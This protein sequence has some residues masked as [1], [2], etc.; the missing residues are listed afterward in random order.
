MDNRIQ[1]LCDFLNSS[2]SVYHAQDYLVNILNEQG[3]T[4]LP[5]AQA[6]D[7]VPGGK[8]YVCRGN[9]TVIA[10]RI[11][12]R[13]PQGFLITAAHTDRPGF[14]VKE[15]GEQFS[16]AYTRL[17]TE[18]YGSPLLGTWTDRPLSL[19]GRVIVETENGAEIRLFDIDR[20]LMLIPNLA[21]HM[22]R[23]SNDGIK[24]NPA[25][26][27][28]PLLGGKEAK[29]KFHDLMEE[30]AGGKIIGHDLYLYV[31]AKAAIWGID[32]EYISAPALDDL[33]SVWGS[34]QGFLKAEESG[35]VPVFCA[36][37]SEEI[38][39]RTANGADSTIISDVL[40][41]ISGALGLDVRQLLAQ[42]FLISADNA[43]ALHPNHPELADVAN[44]PV[45]G[46]GP[47]L[48]FNARQRYC[49]DGLCAAVFRKVCGKA[50][51]NIQTYYNR[52][53]VPGGSTLGC[54]SI[55]HVSIPT[56]DIGLPQLA[57][58]SCYETASVAD[59]LCF[60]DAMR[61]YFSSTLTLS[62]ESFQ[63]Q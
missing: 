35:D 16:A 49:T 14:K 37:N 61:V 36:L 53:D 59:S 31:R 46:Q 1:A 50:G 54:I 29:S 24:W 58:H 48:K 56:A 47:V 11:P 43:H 38:G 62:E 12:N 10:F 27:T 22:N 9:A 21:I 63:L 17:V 5:E 7:I 8:Y 51:V 15:N 26:D 4:A 28:L 41:R 55:S 13:T 52:A 39:S 45:M 25:I 33:Q 32:N 40:A 20:D 60:E 3:Y 30:T 6:W 57:M 19:A 2:H 42:S 34:F 23:Q 44:A 18:V